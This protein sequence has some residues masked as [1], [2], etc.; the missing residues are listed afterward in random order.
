[1]ATSNINKELKEKAPHSVAPLMAIYYG[2]FHG[3]VQAK[4]PDGGLIL[5]ES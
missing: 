2:A 4:F 3:F 1:V 5:G